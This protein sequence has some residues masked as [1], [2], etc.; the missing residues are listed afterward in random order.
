MDGEKNDQTAFQMEVAQQNHATGWLQRG[1]SSRGG[2]T[3]VPWHRTCHSHRHQNPDGP[4]WAEDPVFDEKD[5]ASS[6]RIYGI[7]NAEYRRR[8]AHANDVC[9]R[10]FLKGTPVDAEDYN[11]CRDSLMRGNQ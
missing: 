7:S 10:M 3:V 4:P 11:A 8:E 1:C 2:W 6:A 5:V 9:I